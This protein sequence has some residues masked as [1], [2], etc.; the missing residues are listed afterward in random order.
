[1]ATIALI[2]DIHANLEALQAVLSHID[3]QPEVSKVYCLGDVCGYGP[4]PQAVIDLVNKRCEFALMGNHD[5][6]LLNQPIGFN[7]IAAGAIN[8]QRNALEPGTFSF[9]SK[10]SRWQFL[11]DLLEDKTIGEN[12][13]VHASPRDKIFEYILPED[14]DYNPS[15]LEVVFQLVESR[16]FIGHTHRPGIMTEQPAWYS[17]KD[18]GMEYEFRAEEK[19]II[20][21][22]SVGQPRDRDP[23]A[24]YAVVSETGVRWHRVEYDVQT[25]VRKVRENPCLDDLCGERLLQGR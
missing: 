5:F 12:A 9:P 17:E 15:K 24:C 3:S 16:C 2:S 4:D 22:S 6:A 20:N 11:Q 23:R 21:V 13:F 7:P 25:T 19:L 10:K 8:C 1:M 18:L 14:A